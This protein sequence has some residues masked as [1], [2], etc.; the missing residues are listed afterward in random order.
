MELDLAGGEV[1]TGNV[2]DGNWLAELRADRAVFNA[3]TN[4]ATQYA[5]KYHLD[6]SGQYRRQRESGR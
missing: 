3:Q 4:P 1:L 6:Y 2:D 5:G